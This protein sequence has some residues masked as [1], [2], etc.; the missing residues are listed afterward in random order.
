MMSDVGAAAPPR[1]QPV[2]ADRTLAETGA[3]LCVPGTTLT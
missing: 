2:N 3:G 1:A